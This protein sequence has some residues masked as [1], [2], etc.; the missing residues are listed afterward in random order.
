MHAQMSQAGITTESADNG[1]TTQENQFV[2]LNV[3][4]AAALPKLQQIRNG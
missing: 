2:T 4:H 3:L 1:P